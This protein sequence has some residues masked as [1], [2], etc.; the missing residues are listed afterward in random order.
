MVCLKELL[1]SFDVT[2]EWIYNGKL[3]SNKNCTKLLGFIL[4][5]NNK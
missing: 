1:F 5:A 3:D 4:K 2:V